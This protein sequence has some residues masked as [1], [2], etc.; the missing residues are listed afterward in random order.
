MMSFVDRCTEMAL[1][2]KKSF[3]D[4]SVDDYYSLS[5]GTMISIGHEQYLPYCSTCRFFYDT[6]LSARVSAVNHQC[7]IE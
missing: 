4:L 1:E 3:G 6:R 7:R 2:H 5:F